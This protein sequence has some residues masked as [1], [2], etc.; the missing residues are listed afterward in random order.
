M[1]DNKFKEE[2]LINT[3]SNGEEDTIDINSSLEAPVEIPAEAPKSLGK[4]KWLYPTDEF[5]KMEKGR[6]L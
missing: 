3:D 6:V 4:N 2:K 5:G 1:K